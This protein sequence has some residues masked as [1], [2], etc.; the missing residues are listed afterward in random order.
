MESLLRWGIQ[1][2]APG[3][4]GAAPEPRKDL[5][6]EI[7]DM[8]LGKSDAEQMKEDMAIAI[9]HQRSEDERVDA[10]DHLE[11]L[12]EQIDNANNLEKL[13]MWEPL[14]ELL[15]SDSSTDPVVLQALWVIGT[16]LQNNPA[17]QD[18]Y[19]KLNPL[20]TL[21]S[22]LSPSTSTTPQLRSKVI[23]A[24]SGLLKQNAPALAS[25]EKE[26]TDGWTKLRQGLQDPDI[27]VR[28]KIAFL[29]DA[30]LISTES[31][32]PSSSFSTPSSLHT[33]NS[34]QAPVH[35]NSHAVHL[36][37]PERAGTS[38]LALE[39]MKKHDILPAIIEGLI[40]PLPY[41]EDGDIVEPDPE[42][43]EK[44]VG[45]LRTYAVNC[46]CE[47]SPEQKQAL[48]GWIEKEQDKDGSGGEK[49]LAER[50]DLSGGELRQLM[51]KVE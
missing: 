15:T 11:M 6:P 22:F 9:D 49:G 7:I 8:I 25:M 39:A 19:L 18:S 29:L 33:P 37:N 38:S 40:N 35:A 43:E 27:S 14:H 23:Y 41:G 24:L 21:A 46:N 42:F 34:N 5:N 2:S 1:N 3:G 10:L 32:H 50:W 30:L 48:R 26:G 12:I 36:T 13:K 4:D 17:A 20:P 28:R 47:F 16:A 44:G 45:L 31:T 51:Q